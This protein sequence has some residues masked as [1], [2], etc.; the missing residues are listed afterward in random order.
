[1]KQKVLSILALLLMA[2]SGAWA[3]GPWT[4]G[5][6]TVTLSGGVLTVSKT[7]GN[8]A[9]ADYT[10]PNGQPWKDSRNDITSIVVSEGVIH[11]GNYAFRQCVNA[12]S[13]S[14]PSTLTSIGSNAF[15]RC[16][17]AG[18]TSVAIP[19]NVETIG[20]SAFSNCTGLETAS[21]GSGVTS[22]GQNAFYNCSSLTAFS[23]ADGNTAYSSDGGVLF[24]Q[25][26]TTL[27]QYP[28][29]KS[30]S[31][32]DIPASVT[33]IGNNAFDYCTG[34]TSVTIPDNVTTIGEYAFRNC[35]SMATLTIGSGVTSIGGSAFYGCTGLTSVTIPASVTSIGQNAFRNCSNLATLTVKAASC[36]LGSN[37][38][39]DCGSL[40]AI[41]VPSVKVED[42]KAASNWSTYA[43][44]ILATPTYTVT[45]ADG[46]E[47]AGNW[48]IEPNAGLN[49]NGTETVTIEY[50][51]T[52]RVQSV[53]AVKKAG[54]DVG[55]ALSASAVGE[56][57]GSDGK[58]YAVADKDNLPSG[59]TAVAMVAYKSETT[60]SSLAIALA[61]EADMM[62]WDTAKSTCEG[63]TAVT[64]AA[65]LFPSQNQWKDML[66][67]FSGGEERY[68]ELNTAITN[69]G[70]TA[71][72]VQVT[73][74]TSDEA[75]S[76]NNY[77]MASVLFFNNEETYEM[78][79][80]WVAFRNDFQYSTFFARAVLAF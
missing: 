22:I 74:W 62:N 69:A 20:S 19:D 18:F 59:V 66:K 63:K 25:D 28:A 34:L 39:K 78:A 72:Q 80:E 5:D 44:K 30:G 38:F 53:T 2:V 50:T 40:T 43:D 56:I 46:T 77:P 76:F 8:G 68:Q 13:V 32:Y 31:S 45:L 52:K 41:Y 79:N 14:L 1:M 48:T 9:M 24:N 33:S 16:N 73:Y 23:V 6:C 26:K 17:N 4:S 11:V 60:G 75:G 42:Y 71:L 36:T 29:G 35:S 10:G 21:I 65:W 70:G 49:G 15:Y 61:D 12:A 37:A 55:H 57:V 54:A 67:A 3:Q 27:V 7:S 64:G 58:A 51:G 47:D